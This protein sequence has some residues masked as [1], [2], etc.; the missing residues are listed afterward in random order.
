M[1][2][3]GFFVNMTQVNLLRKGI[4]EN[5]NQEEKKEENKDEQVN[6]WQ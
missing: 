1:F 6:Q 3:N 5:D 2:T 4:S